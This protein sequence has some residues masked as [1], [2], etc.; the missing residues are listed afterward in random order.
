[1]KFLKVLISLLVVALV[2]PA[3]ADTL[4]FTRTNIFPGGEMI[5]FSGSIDSAAIDTSGNFNLRAYDHVS[6]ATLP[7]SFATY[8]ASDDSLNATEYVDGSMD[9]T[10]WTPVDTLFT[11][12]TTSGWYYH[13]ADFNNKKFK[14]Y[15]AR[16]QNVYTQADTSD[17]TFQQYLL[18]Y[19]ED[20]QI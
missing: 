17:L 14:V 5:Y 1:M 8:L 11:N 6:W 20:R 12:R 19:Q 18:L 16:V 13:T 2:V 4:A 15:R 10:N 7:F 3:M 9:G